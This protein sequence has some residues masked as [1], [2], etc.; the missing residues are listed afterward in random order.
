[1]LAIG[2]IILM[3]R[4]FMKKKIKSKL[5]SILYGLLFLPIAIF[6]AIRCYFKVPY[7]FC[8]A[9]PIKC[10]WGVLAPVIIPS[11]LVLNLDKRLWCFQMCPFGTIQD[12]QCKCVKKTVCLPKWL[13]NIRYL[14]LVF[15]L[16]VVVGLFI[17]LNWLS[18][19]LKETH[20]LYAWSLTIAAIIFILAFFIPR[21]WCNYFCPIGSFGDI[22]LKIEKKVKK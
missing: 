6:P 19:F 18:W 21:F 14:F 1:M 3:L 12:Y 15:T 16:V 22:A 7:I 8:K 13:T 4:V 17:N 2:L 5:I 20:H 9:C 10:P 11:F